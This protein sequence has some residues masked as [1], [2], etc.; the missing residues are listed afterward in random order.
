MFLPKKKY[1]NLLR[2]TKTIFSDIHRKISHGSDA[3]LIISN[4]NFSIL[5]K[6]FANNKNIITNQY[7]IK[8]VCSFTMQNVK[9]NFSI[10]EKISE[11]DYIN[12]EDFIVFL[13]NY[14]NG[15][16]DLRDFPPQYKKFLKEI[17]L[18]PREPDEPDD[19]CGKDCVP[20][21]IEFYHEKLDRRDE[22][23]DDLYRKIYPDNSKEENDEVAKSKA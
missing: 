15:E 13:T 17:K 21:K 12:K 16:I 9:R 19:C 10:L 5:N 18:I 7:N 14:Q 22:M 20:C 4:K 23:I 3:R 2:T 11:N 6:N 1:A 8:N